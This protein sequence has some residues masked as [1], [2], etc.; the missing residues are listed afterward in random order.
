VV[1]AGQVIP[2]FEEAV[3]KLKRYEKAKVILPYNIA[4]GTN[5]NSSIPG[6]SPLYFE[7]EVVF[8]Q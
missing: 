4:Y 8:I 7:I 5:G 3:K 6:Y 2:G 1:G